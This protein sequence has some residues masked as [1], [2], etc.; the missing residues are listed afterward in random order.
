MGQGG[1]NRYPFQFVKE[2]FEERGY[3]LLENN[4]INNRTPLKYL[5]P[6]HGQ[7]TIRFEHLL[8][9]HGCPECGR[10]RRFA[11]TNTH[12]LSKHPCYSVW[13][14]M[15]SRCY[16]PKNRWYHRYGGRGITVCD[17]WR[18]GPTAFCAW[19]EQN[20][21]QKGVS[22]DRIRNNEGYA[23]DNCRWAGFD[24]QSNNTCRNLFI[25]LYGRRQTAGQW[26]REMGLKPGTVASRVKSGYFKR[27]GINPQASYDLKEVQNK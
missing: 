9:D 17:E 19:A 6:K 20:G 8:N 21:Y 18:Y 15:I 1:Q 24:Y 2:K 7:H 10:E 13:K 3:V 12:H 14:D 23:P 25:T 16:N 22:L 26:D 27:R 4:Y 5:C 11:N